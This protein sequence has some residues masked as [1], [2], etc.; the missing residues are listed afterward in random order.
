LFC[1]WRRSVWLN[2]YA[3]Q[4]IP[5]I[6]LLALRGVV[7]VGGWIVSKCAAD[8]QHRFVSVAMH[9]TSAKYMSRV[10]AS[11]PW[12][13]SESLLLWSRF[14]KKKDAMTEM[15]EQLGAHRAKEFNVGVNP[16]QLGGHPVQRSHSDSPHQQQL[17]QPCIKCPHAS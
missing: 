7:G 13:L 8:A 6:A 2:Q 15:A 1:L 17:Q 3:R 14:S 12:F 11:C 5:I 10:A 4:F 16:N 9:A